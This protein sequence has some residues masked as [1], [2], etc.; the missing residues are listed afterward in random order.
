[1]PTL[2]F[3]SPAKSLERLGLH[4]LLRPHR[5]QDA[6]APLVLLRPGP[7]TASPP[8]VLPSSLIMRALSVFYLLL[9]LLGSVVSQSSDILGNCCYF[10]PTSVIS[11]SEYW[12]NFT[13]VDLVAP[14]GSLTIVTL[15]AGWTLSPNLDGTALCTSLQVGTVNCTTNRVAALRLTAPAASVGPPQGSNVVLMVG[16]D[17]CILTDKCG[18]S[19][20]TAPPSASS[21]LINMGPLGQQPLWL[22][23]VVVVGCSLFVIGVGYVLYRRYYVPRAD[24][25]DP[26]LKRPIEYSAGSM[27]AQSAAANPAP[28]QHRD[29]PRISTKVHNGHGHLS[30]SSSRAGFDSAQGHGYPSSDPSYVASAESIARSPASRREGTPR[31]ATYK[32]ESLPRKS[33][34][35]STDPR[36]YSSRSRGQLVSPR[37]DSE[38]EDDETAMAQRLATISRPSK[39]GDSGM[40][41]GSG[42]G[43]Q[44]VPVHSIVRIEEDEPLANTLRRHGNKTPTPLVSFPT[45]AHTAAESDQVSPRPHVSSPPPSGPLLSFREEAEPSSQSRRNSLPRPARHGHTKS[46]DRLV[47]QAAPLVSFNDERPSTAASLDRRKQAKYDTGSM[48]RKKTNKADSTSLER[49]KSPRTD[50]TTLERRHQHELLPPSDSLSPRSPDRGQKSLD[51][52]SRSKRATEP[53]D[54]DIPLASVALRAL[55]KQLQSQQPEDSSRSRS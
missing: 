2:F 33:I 45:A 41:L 13:A 34:G 27:L 14:V 5:I 4:L 11:P 49:R 3:T 35:S 6:P 40:A 36:L 10:A 51:R 38:D 20:V 37:V 32:G 31:T 26:E 19:V 18:S 30:P 42:L 25:D 43:D 29:V 22:F 16:T 15:P 8:P 21:G 23:I 53:A 17:Q 39:S 7:P 1:S 12:F 52:S 55:Q 46:T 28:T 9:A 48:E 50:S 47:E 44:F 54:D 24:R